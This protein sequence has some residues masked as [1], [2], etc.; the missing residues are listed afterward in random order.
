MGCAL[1][2]LSLLIAVAARATEP[3]PHVFPYGGIS[4]GGRPVL[5]ADFSLDT[6]VAGEL[7]RFPMWTP[8]ITPCL[9]LRPGIVDTIQLFH[10]ALSP[11]RMVMIPYDSFGVGFTYLTAGTYYKAFYDGWN[12]TIGGIDGHLWAQNGQQFVTSTQPALNFGIAWLDSTED[13]LCEVALSAGRIDGWFMDQYGS[14]ASFLNGGDCHCS[15][16]D[17]ARAG[18]GSGSAMDL[19][20]QAQLVNLAARVHNHSAFGH[21]ARLIVNGS[22]PDTTYHR[23]LDGGM[24]ENWP[25]LRGF[26]AGMDVYLKSGPWSTITKTCSA[27]QTIPNGTQYNST[28]LREARFVLGSASMGDGWGGLLQPPDLTNPATGSTWLDWYYDEYSV[29]LGNNATADTTGAHQGWL[30]QALGPA[31]QL[32]ADVWIRYFEHGA[33]VLNGTVASVIVP[34]DLGRSYRKILGV[35]DPTI[36]NGAYVSSVTVAASDAIFLCTTP[37]CR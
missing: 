9:D 34:L 1:A 28:S 5:K 15:H 30:G 16:P 36:N 3:F 29:D 23:T 14:F 19:A 37:D 32:I 31:T 13:S 35:R 2:A 7:A 11:R 17:F 26:T 24:F 33:V 18:F 12:R 10:A 20:R 4:G 27:C 8:N 22:S 25:F 21:V 6:H